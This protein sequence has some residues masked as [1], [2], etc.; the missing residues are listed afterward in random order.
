MGLSRAL[1]NAV[2]PDAAAL[3]RREAI[4]AT[5]HD[6][7]FFLGP[8]I[9]RDEAVPPEAQELLRP[10]AIFSRTYQKYGGLR[11]HVLIVH[12]SDARDMIGHYPPVCYPSAGWVPERVPGSSEDAIELGRVRLPVRLY[13]FQRMREHGRED[14]IRICN[15]FILPG[16][17]VSREISDINRQSERRAVSAQ[18]VAQLQVIVPAGLDRTE[19]MEAAGELLGAMHD[20]FSVLQVRGRSLP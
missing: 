14:R 11:L 10:N 5:M 18:G 7:P 17:I 4:A 13:Q 20:L 3:Q 12:C 19:A 1:P 9:G 16:G 15:A 2:E 6:V 8:W